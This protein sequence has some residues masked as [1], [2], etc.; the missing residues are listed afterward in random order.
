M[1]TELDKILSLPISDDQKELIVSL[2]VKRLTGF[3]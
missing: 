2:N 3:V 1:K